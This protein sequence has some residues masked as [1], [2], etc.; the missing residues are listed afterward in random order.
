MQLCGRQTAGIEAAV[1][2]TRSVFES[3]DY[4][5]VLLVD[6][7]NTLNFNAVNRKAAFRRTTELFYGRKRHTFAGIKV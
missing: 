3:G 6:A 7:S 2:A 1:H 5:A 4:E